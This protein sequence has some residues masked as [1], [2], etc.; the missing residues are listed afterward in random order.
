MWVR[1][2][3]SA[4]GST[5][6]HGHGVVEVD[7][8]VERLL[9]CQRIGERRRHGDYGLAD[10]GPRDPHD[11][12]SGI[13]GLAGLGIAAGDDPSEVGAKPREGERILRAAER[14]LGALEVGR[15]GLAALHDQVELCLRRD[16]ALDQRALARLL[17]LGVAELRFGAVDGRLGVAHQ[18][19]LQGGIE[20]GEL[21]ALLHHRADVDEA[22][23][24]AAE[25][26]EAVVR[27]I[28]RL[29]TAGERPQR[30][31]GAQFGLDRQ[32]GPDRRSRLLV[33]LAGAERQAGD[34]Q[35]PGAA[36]RHGLISTFWPGRSIWPPAKTM[37]WP[38]SMSPVTAIVSRL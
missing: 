26:A 3:G 24:H 32:D 29:N 21:V 35:Q 2:T 17:G 15:G 25:Q 5:P 33:F 11:L 31:D 9:R 37:V 30:V 7:Y 16:V 18:Q 6:L 19:R 14:R 10:F 23:H 27:G 1:V 12:L 20:D 34:Q 8:H 28:A 38:G 36:P 13:D 22:R 4:A